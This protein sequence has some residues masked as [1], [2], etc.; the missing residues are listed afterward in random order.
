MQ[1]L[2]PLEEVRQPMC[3]IGI[4]LIWIIR[5]EGLPRRQLRVFIG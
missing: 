5:P 3:D 4:E 1:K 2:K